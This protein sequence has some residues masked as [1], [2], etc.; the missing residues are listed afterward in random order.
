MIDFI[1]D[2]GDCALELGRTFHN[3][4]LDQVADVPSPANALIP[5]VEYEAY[6]EC[7]NLLRF[8]DDAGSDVR[9]GF[10]DSDQ[11]AYCFYVDPYTGKEGTEFGRTPSEAL[12]TALVAIRAGRIL[13]N[14][15]AA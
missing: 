4:G 6:K 14:A 2:D 7:A 10:M 12:T 9:V 8:L 11:A 15:R 1:L 5:A 3:E 13:R